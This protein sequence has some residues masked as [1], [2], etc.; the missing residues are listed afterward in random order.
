MSSVISIVGDSLKLALLYF[1]NKFSK[2]KELAEKVKD[3][4]SKLEGAIESKNPA[5][6]INWFIRTKRM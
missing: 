6:V 2:K 3:Q 1:E 5:S 4:K